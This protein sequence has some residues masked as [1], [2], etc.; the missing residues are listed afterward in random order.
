MRFAAVV[1]VD[2]IECNGRGAVSSIYRD[3]IPQC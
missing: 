1:F 3:P 2:D